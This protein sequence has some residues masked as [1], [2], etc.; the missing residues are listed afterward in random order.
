[1][2]KTKAVYNPDT[3]SFMTP[4]EAKEKGV[5]KEERFKVNIG[6]TLGGQLLECAKADGIDT[7]ADT[8]MGE[9]VRQ[10]NAVG[11]YVKQA[12]REFLAA[13]QVS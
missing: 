5:S 6:A 7:S 8:P 4:A 3:H 1:M 11:M 2:A 10:T 12:I 13:R 9:K